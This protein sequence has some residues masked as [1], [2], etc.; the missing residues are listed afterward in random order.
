LELLEEALD[1][2]Q[3]EIQLFRCMQVGL[4]CVQEASEDRP[5][6]SEVVIILSSEDMVLPQPNRPAFYSTTRFVKGGW[7]CSGSCTVNEITFTVPQGR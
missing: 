7:S 5:T 1:R 6:M 4:L 2:P 3:N